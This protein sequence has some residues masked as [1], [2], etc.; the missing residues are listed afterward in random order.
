MVGSLTDT[1][2]GKGTF[3]SYCPLNK[4]SGGKMTKVYLGGTCNKSI[5]RDIVIQGLKIDYY[6]PMVPDRTS[7]NEEEEVRQRM[8]CD[9]ILYVIT[10]KMAGF[11]S[12]AELVD[13]SNKRPKDTYFCYLIRDEQDTFSNDQIYSLQSIAKLVRSNGVTI[14]Y[15]LENCTWALNDRR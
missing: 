4:Y 3:E 15:S 6:N 11:Y 12:I 2:T 7:R 8:E 1:I 10:P 5:W 14:C 9:L 13:D